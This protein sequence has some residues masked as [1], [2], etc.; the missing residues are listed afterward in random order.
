M[1]FDFLND[2]EFWINLFIG[3]VGIF[4]G[5]MAYKEANKAFSEAGKAKDAATAA[6]DAANKAGIDGKK[7]INS[8]SNFRNNSNVSNPGKFHIRRC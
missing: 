8:L 5:W 3:L 4:I 7:T 2:I 1:K 6:R